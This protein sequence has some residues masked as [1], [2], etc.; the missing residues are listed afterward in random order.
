[1][2]PLAQ[3]F[4]SGGHF[5]PD[6]LQAA[7][8]ADRPAAVAEVPLDLTR[9]R[10]QGVCGETAPAAAPVAADGLDQSQASHLQ[11]VLEVDAPSSVAVCDGIREV[12]GQQHYFVAKPRDLAPVATLLYATQ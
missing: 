4:L 8:G 12:E 11:E 10:G 6:L 9:D 5:G 2:Q 7:R 3:V 1:M